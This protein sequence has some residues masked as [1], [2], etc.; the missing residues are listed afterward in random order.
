MKITFALVAAAAIAATTLPAQTP[1]AVTGSTNI[2]IGGLLAVGLKQSTWSPASGQ[3]YSDN[4]LGDNTSRLTIMSTSKI[5]DGWNVI[6]RLGSRFEANYGPGT[7]ILPGVPYSPVNVLSKGA[8]TGSFYASLAEDDTW[9]GISSPYGTITFGKSTIWI[10]DSVDMA[11][12]GVP[13]A[14][15]SYRI[16]DANGLAVFNILDTAMTTAG[17]S[18]TLNITRSQDVLQYISPKFSDVQFQI[19]WS[20]NP[21]GSTLQNG[22]ATNGLNYENGDTLYAKIQYNHGPINAFLSLLDIKAQ[23]GPGPA[24]LPLPPLGTPNVEAYRAGISYK[25]NGFKA[26]VT[27]DHTA[28]VLSVGAAAQSRTAFMIPVSYSWDKHGVYATYASAGNMST[29]GKTMDATGANQIN[30]VYDYALTPRAFLGVYFTNL[31]NDTNGLYNPFLSGTNLGPS[32]APGAG[33]TWHQ[34]GIN[35]NYWF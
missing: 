30:L 33:A 20:K 31:K 7:S 17:A 18:N 22:A 11:Y 4:Y 27:V 5:T 12:L 15:E 29:Q 23:G 3:S 2:T 8:S 9:G 26:G 24:Y 14:G 32:G 34:I 28:N 10:T 1:I 6:F 21:Y 25:A 35:M 13:S 16:W 19:A